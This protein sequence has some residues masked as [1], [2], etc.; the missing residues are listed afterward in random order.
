M[1]DSPPS[2]AQTGA[3]TRKPLP[4]S[5]AA[6]R[7]SRFSAYSEQQAYFTAVTK[8]RLTRRLDRVLEIAIAMFLYGWVY[9]EAVGTTQITSLGFYTL[10]SIDAPI[11]VVAI[12]CFFSI[13]YIIKVK[14]SFLLVFT[15]PCFILIFNSFTGIMRSSAQALLEMRYW[16]T[17]AFI[18][19]AAILTPQPR[20]ILFRCRRYA[21]HASFALALL[22]YLRLA[23][24]PDF[25]YMNST[26]ANNVND[27]G[28]GLS[29]QG[30]TSLL[31]G[32]W[33]TFLQPSPPN[34]R[35]RIKTYAL[36]L[37]LIAGLFL[38]KQGTSSIAAGL[39]LLIYAAVAYRPLR[40]VGLLALPITAIASPLI[41]PII[42]ERIFG[43]AFLAHRS[44]NL[45]T[46]ELV[47][48]GFSRLFDAQSPLI[49]AIGWPLGQM[50]IF[51]IHIGGIN[52]PWTSS[53]HSMY[54]GGLKSM[55]YVGMAFLVL[56]I[57]L[58][59]IKNVY[60]FSSR[61][62]EISLIMAMSVLTLFI[63]FYSYEANSPIAMILIWPILAARMPSTHRLPPR[64]SRKT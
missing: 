57:F 33:L 40:P 22:V 9:T 55:G 20:T 39:T 53:L 59:L 62:V 19:L 63:S 7:A 23:I 30:A 16:Y 58:L 11:V 36:R 17:L 6:K 38:S 49:K 31:M 61:K 1:I 28:R 60:D 46:R 15:I 18:P 35:R 56:A 41:L 50:P 27:G 5:K 37:F 54:F 4:N 8:G 2:A 24:G 32:F 45:Q 14:P 3:W 42:L 44:D 29:S 48:T 10:H 47:W 12:Y 43:A 52:L 34:M 51:T 21:I 26:L 64:M 13:K 25:L